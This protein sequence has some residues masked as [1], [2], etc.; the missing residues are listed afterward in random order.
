MRTD[1]LSA[2]RSELQGVEEMS[3]KMR[4]LTVESPLQVFGAELRHWRLLR[5]LSQAGLGRATHDSGALIGRIEKAERRP[6]LAFARRMDT[7]LD[8][9]GTLE[10]LWHR[11]PDSNDRTSTTSTPLAGV[12]ADPWEGMAIPDLVTEWLS[13]SQ[14]VST[15][16]SGP[17][18]IGRVD[19]EVMWSMCAAMTTADHH[20]G[21][22]YARD[23]LIA[24]LSHTVAPALRG[25]YSTAIGAE[26]HTVAARLA[27]LAGFMCFDSAR[28]DAAQRYFRSALQLAKTA[29]NPAL[30]AHILAD[31]AMQAHHADRPSD[32][33][34][35]A[36]A[37]VS[38][39]LPTDSPMT[40]ARSCA[41]LA[42]AHALN[43]DTGAAAEALNT[44]ER[45]LDRAGDPLDEPV[46]IRFFTTE[47]LAAEAMYTASD[48]GAIDIVQAHAPPVLAASSGMERRHVLAVATLAGS[49]LH[50]SIGCNVEQACA[51]LATALPT[52]GSVTSSRG[53]DAVNTVRRR[54]TRFSD[55]PVVRDL[56]QRYLTALTGSTT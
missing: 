49:Y 32:A 29:A 25:S 52:V 20:L 18:L 35:L 30:G 15:T 31:M 26:L 37:A 47:Q 55:L 27:N 40:K 28:H 10:R 39:A 11:I 50:G 54:L 56:E 13:R 3:Q 23:T 22:G 38:T 51:V 36:D 6:N 21:G 44:A 14:P 33:I 43:G 9:G 12:L 42:R 8:T 16:S 2:S 46:W 34:T 41:L 5:N 17:R 4:E 7:A 48:S 53:I 1:V 19:I 24:F 45:H